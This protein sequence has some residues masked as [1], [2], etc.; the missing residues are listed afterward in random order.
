[1]PALPEPR[2]QLSA[3]LR[4]LPQVRGTWLLAR[5]VSLPGPRGLHWLVQG[6]R[7]VGGPPEDRLALPCQAVEGLAPGA[8]LRFLRSP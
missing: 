5:G 4:R 6:M 8:R 2:E 1:M 7:E 3:L